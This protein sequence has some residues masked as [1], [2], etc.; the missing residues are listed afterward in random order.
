MK[1]FHNHV[2]YMYVTC[3]LYVCYMYVICM[4]ENEYITVYQRYI[5]YMMYVNQKKY[6]VN[7]AI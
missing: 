1:A 6:N 7:Q 5:Q 3:M 4:L 2:C